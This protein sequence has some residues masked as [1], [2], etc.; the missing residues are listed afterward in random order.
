MRRALIIFLI[1]LISYY[2][3]GQTTTPCVQTLRLAR[4]TYEQGRLHEIEGQLKPCLEGGFTKDEK[5]LKVEGYK[6]L[7]LSY[8][9]LEEPEKANEAMLNILRTDHD[10]Q[11]NPAVDPAEFVGLYKTFRSKSLF[12]IGLT[13]GPNA[14]MPS[15]TENF[16]VSG[17]ATGEGKYS[18]K[19]NVQIGLVFEK[20]LAGKFTAAPE[21][22]FSNRAFTYSNSILFFYDSAENSASASQ[23]GEIRQSWLDLNLLVQ[24]KLGNGPLNSYVSFGPNVGMLLNATNTIETDYTGSGTG[25]VTSGPPVDIKDTYNKFGFSL[26]GTAG[27][28]YKF[29]AIYITANVRYQF[30]LSKI[31]NE[32]KKSN[33]ETIYDYALGPN[34]YTQNN[35]AFLIGFVYPIFSPKKL[36]VKK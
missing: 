29:G 12:S 5:Q 1:S 17:S 20:H 34:V 30:G 7:C 22:A 26:I 27:L 2:S 10:F 13:V 19:V 33:P 8:I 6:L 3:F 28:K 16:A 21:L 18:P 35:A 32:D 23:I 4:A 14:T 25:Q 15:V 9:Y 24:Y 36:Q 31:V 11:I